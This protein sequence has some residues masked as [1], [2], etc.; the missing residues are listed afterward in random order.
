MK[1]KFHQKVYT[2]LV[3]VFRNAGITLDLKQTERI[4]HTTGELCEVIQEQAR[5]EAV[6]LMR[7]LQE[8]VSDGFNTVYI[9]IER[10]NN[11]LENLQLKEEGED[12]TDSRGAGGRED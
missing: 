12:G 7:K 1:N 10:L 8:A 3:Q 9:D 11:R 4:E 5:K 6:E 2:T